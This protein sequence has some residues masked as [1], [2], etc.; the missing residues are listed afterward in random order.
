MDDVPASTAAHLAADLNT[1]INKA[2]QAE[3]S[4]P[5]VEF[6]NVAECIDVDIA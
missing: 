3:N 4:Q 1:A 6:F 2:S 5:E